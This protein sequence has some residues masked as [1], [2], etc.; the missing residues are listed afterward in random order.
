MSI[1]RSLV[2]LTAVNLVL[3]AAAWSRPAQ[4]PEVLRARSIELV[5]SAGQVRAQL[6]LGPDGSGQ[7]RLRDGR[8]QVRVKLGTSNTG[9]TA[10]LLM[11]ETIEPAVTLATR[12]EGVSLTLRGPGGRQRVVEP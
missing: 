4:S 8:G 2:A 12:R 10:L 1:Q 6:H 11:D 7:L 9:A 3:S 5:D